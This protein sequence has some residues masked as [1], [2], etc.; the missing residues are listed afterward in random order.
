MPS[1]GQIN[2]K[3]AKVAAALCDQRFDRARVRSEQLGNV[4]NRQARAEQD[5]DRR[6][7]STIRLE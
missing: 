1:L 7:C 2:P 6:G 5:A 4:A 3:L